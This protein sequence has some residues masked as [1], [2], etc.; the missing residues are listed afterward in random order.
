MAILKQILLIAG[1]AGVISAGVV[2]A[3]NK[4][5]AVKGVIG[6]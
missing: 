1:V 2:Y 5:P 3:S 4:V 6:A